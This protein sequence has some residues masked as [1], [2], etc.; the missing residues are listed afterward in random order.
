MSNCCWNGPRFLFSQRGKK[1]KQR[2]TKFQCNQRN[3]GG[4]GG[5]SWELQS[6]GIKLKNHCYE[7]KYLILSVG[8]SSPTLSCCFFRN[9]V[10]VVVHKKFSARIWC[11]WNMKKLLCM[12][13][14][15]VRI[16]NYAVNAIRT[17]SRRT[18][19]NI[20]VVFSCMKFQCILWAWPYLSH[21]LHYFPLLTIFASLFWCCHFTKTV[22]CLDAFY[23]ELLLIGSCFLEHRWA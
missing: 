16:G 10:V 7:V 20:C 12:S 13:N 9:D 23:G 5:F 17:R 18:Q 1:P 14:G 22:L 4:G 2:A 6:V 15:M 19:H 3:R 8:R 21:S 11:A